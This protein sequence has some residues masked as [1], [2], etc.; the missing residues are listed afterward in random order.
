MFWKS[1]LISFLIN[2]APLSNK[3]KN[4]FKNRFSYKLN[5]DL[6]CIPEPEPEPNPII[7]K[8]PETLS[9]KDDVIILKYRDTAINKEYR[10]LDGRFPINSTD[11]DNDIILNVTKNMH[12]LDLLIYLENSDRSIHNKISLIEQH[13]KDEIPSLPAPNIKMGALF[14]DWDA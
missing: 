12:K 6:D 5:I 7:S 4:I 14:K 2:N 10:G 1:F 8:P 13:L 11:Y 3:I 9:Y